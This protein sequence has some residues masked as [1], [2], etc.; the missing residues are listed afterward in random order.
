MGYRGMFRRFTFNYIMVISILAGLSLV[1]LANTALAQD[2]QTYTLNIGKKKQQFVV[3]EAW[4]RQ[5]VNGSLTSTDALNKLI[6]ATARVDLKKEQGTAF[7]LGKFNGEHLML[8]NFHVMS[9]RDQ[10]KTGSIYF[11]YLKKSFRCRTIIQKFKDFEATFFT[12]SVSK[13]YEY[14]LEDVGLK[15]DFKNEYKPGHK[16]VTAGYGTH[17][18]P[19]NHLTYEN[20]QTCVVATT[21]FKSNFLNVVREGVT[22]GAHS[23]VHACELSPGDSGSALVSETSGKV[24]GLNWATSDSK[25]T[26]LLSGLNVFN[27]ID[28]QVPAL[29][30][31]MSYAVSATNIQAAIMSSKS[32]TLNEFSSAQSLSGE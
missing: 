11:E 1:L 28:K 22:Y 27:W 21:N 32:V 26:E 23:F 13:N 25:P 17:L 7:Y 12:I 16:V 4:S 14:M 24:I 19:G 29:W 6:K 31:S 5:F 20:S 30:N 8:T 2:F 10:C 15:F 9:E 18:N 3:G